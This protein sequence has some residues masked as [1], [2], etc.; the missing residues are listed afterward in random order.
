L[1]AARVVEKAP[2]EGS[3]TRL[4]EG[5]AHGSIRPMS[6]LLAREGAVRERR[7]PRQRAHDHTP[8]LWATGPHPVWSWAI[9]QLQGPVKWRYDDL[10]VRLAID[11]REVGGWMGAHRERAALAHQLRQLT[12]NKQ[13]SWPG[14]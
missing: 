10:Y 8:E 7:G 1:P 12:G 6:R 3:A 9:T 14:P 2:L 4:D 5:S 11:S 13:G